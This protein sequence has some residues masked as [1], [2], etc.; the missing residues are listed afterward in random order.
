MIDYK[1][2]L[3]TTDSK[4]TLMQWLQTL[5]EEFENAQIT[6]VT[7][8]NDGNK[9]LTF[10]FKLEDGTTK[11]ATI[12]L[13]SLTA[14]EQSLINNLIKSVTASSDGV[15]FSQ[16]VSF[17][18]NES[19]SGSEIHNGYASFLGDEN[20][21]GSELHK[22]EATF[23]Q[24]KAD[25]ITA[26]DGQ[27]LMSWDGTTTALKGNADRPS[28]NGGDLALKSDVTDIQQAQWKE[29]YGQCNVR[30]YEDKSFQI[31]TNVNLTLSFNAVENKGTS[32]DS[33]Y[34][35]IKAVNK[36]GGEQVHVP[37]VLSSNNTYNFS[38]GTIVNFSCMFFNANIKNTL[39]LPA[40]TN[41][42]VYLS[43]AFLGSKFT[44]ILIANNGSMKANDV[45][46]M[47]ANCTNLT[48][49][50]NFDLSNAD[51]EYY[52][53]KG[54]SN[55]KSVH[56]THFK[57]SFLINSSTKFEEADLVEIIGNLDPVS[58]TQTLT[59]GST[60]LAKLTSDEILVATGKGWALA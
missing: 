26:T 33:M 60:N 51:N 28:Y 42:S 57:H 25:D 29:Y 47:C 55:L 16:A 9:S 30:K 27:E 31:Y 5:T 56:C 10:T 58:T 4:V 6:D 37:V 21:A 41:G 53:F 40:F 50:G 52:M 38:W 18:G 36:N 2:I 46:L 23:T 11:T 45:D 48:E 54:C 35:E 15:T 44:K 59:M 24:L 49:V 7:F 14:D 17:Q 13:H 43:R 22:G 39:T 32:Y 12:E 3:S 1:T 20:H 34:M 19:H 8:T